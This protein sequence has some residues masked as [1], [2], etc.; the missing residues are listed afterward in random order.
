VGSRAANLQAVQRIEAW[1]KISIASHQTV[2]VETVLSTAKYRKLVRAAKTLRFKIALF[3]VILNSPGLHVARVRLRVEKGG[4]HVE[5]SK[6]LARRIRSLSQLPWFLQEADEAWLYD[7]SGAS[8]RLMG[9]KR[10][11]TMFLD[12]EALP[13]IRQAVNKAVTR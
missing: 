11:G 4:H 3:Y 12:A 2:G 7:N 6:I 5:K 9:Q 13:E 10:Q 1:L 8:P